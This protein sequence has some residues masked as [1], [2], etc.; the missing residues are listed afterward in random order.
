[1]AKIRFLSVIAKGVESIAH[2]FLGSLVNVSPVADVM[3]INA[4]LPISST[5]RWTSSRTELGN[6]SNAWENVGDQI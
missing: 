3:E 1:V 4:T 2:R 5:L 6:E